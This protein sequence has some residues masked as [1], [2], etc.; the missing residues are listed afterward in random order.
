MKLCVVGTGYVGLVAGTCFAESGNDVVCVDIVAAKIEALQRGEVPIYEPGL[1]ELIRRNVAEG[2]LAFTIDLP[3]AVRASRVCFVAVGTPEDHDGSADL[4]AVLAVGRAIA[5]AMDGPRIVV[6]KST[7]PV[8]THAKIR[9]EM[10]RHTTH[11]FDVV[12]NPE[13]MKEGAAIEDFL[14]PDRVVIGAASAR[15][16]EIMREVYE[17]FV[18]TGNPIL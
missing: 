13:F 3:T 11:P 1:A 8:G 14:K 12:S 10:A 6:T 4:S 16:I 2:R 15:A 17:P 18:R 9:A 7:V 5:Q